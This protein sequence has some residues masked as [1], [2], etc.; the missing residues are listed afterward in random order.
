MNPAEITAFNKIF[1]TTEHIY[2]KMITTMDL[3]SPPGN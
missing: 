3:F 2:K 1:I